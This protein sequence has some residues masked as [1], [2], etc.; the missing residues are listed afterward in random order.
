MKKAIFALLVIVS[1]VF[2]W[3]STSVQ[4]FQIITRDVIEREVVTITDLIK[5]VDNF[6]VLFD[7]SGSTNQMVPGKNI[8][9]IKAAKDLLKE[10]NA[11][12]PDLGHKAGLYIYT[13]FETL[14]G[15]FKEVYGM[16]TYDRDGFAAAIDQLPEKG[17]GPTML[18]P[19][20]RGLRKTLAGLTGKT[21]VIMF[22]D[23]T[24]STV[25]GPKSAKQ[26]ARE[27]T[28]DNNVCF[29]LVSTATE[30]ENAKLL[31]EVS[32]VNACSRVVPLSLF[33]DNPHYM[34]GALFAVRTTSYE[35]LVPAKEIVGVVANDMLFD[36]NSSFIRDE[37][38][39]KLDMLGTYLQNKPEAF[40]VAAGFTDNVGDEEYNLWLSE[41]RVSRV[42]SYLV[43]RFGIDEHRIV[44]LWYGDFN[45]V[46]DNTTVE[47]RQLNRRVEIAVGGIN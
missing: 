13:D 47:G 42:Q 46:A 33:M 1:L 17:Q 43:D 39:E 37:Y 31:E 16:K 21:A 12:F 29:Y 41:R 18:Q 9:K 4:A 11:W 44:T 38:E 24:F 23:G 40:V 20:L 32:S 34:S 10:R 26:I 7:T 45:P 35:R 22:T 27:I 5:T 14:S 19:A 3:G 25:R 2:A 28:H 36:F 15:T 30:D 8:S 6:I